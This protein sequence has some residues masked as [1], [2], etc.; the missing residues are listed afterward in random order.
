M[1]I[2]LGSEST[3]R[4]RRFYFPLCSL[5]FG[6]HRWGSKFR[7]SRYSNSAIKR[8]QIGRI[9]PMENKAESDPSNIT[10]A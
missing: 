1:W 6:R 7:N 3:A 9:L 8:R 2:L 5:R 4:S 10:R